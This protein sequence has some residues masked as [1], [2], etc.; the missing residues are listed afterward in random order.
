MR[1]RGFTLVELMVALALGMAVTIAVTLM[2]ARQEGARRTLTSTNDVAMTGAFLSFTLDRQLRSAGSGYSQQWQD[3]FGC[4]MN[5]ARDGD[6]LLPRPGAFPAPFAGVPQDVRLVPVLVHARAGTA[7]SDVLQVLTGAS[8]RG[9]LPVRLRQLS[10]TGSGVRIPNT[11]GLRGGDLVMLADPAL[12]CVLQQVEDGFAGSADQSL[13]FGGDYAAAQVNGVS[14]TAFGVDTLSWVVPLGNV[15]GNTPSFE[16][17]GLGPRGTLFTYDL[18]RLDGSD[19][20]LPVADGVVQLRALYG[21]DSDDDGRLD[22]WADP[23]VAPFDAASLTSGTDDAVRNLRRIVALR[24]GM[25]LRSAL[26]ERDVVANAEVTLFA[27]LGEEFA[28]A[29]EIDDEDRRQRHRPVEFTVP[30]R[31]VLMLP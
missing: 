8:G 27:D 12:G 19:A 15:E 25:V 28:F 13:P 24:V 16:L 4:P 26:I 5:V 31:N 29:V 30:L 22:A 23:A 2:M 7:A 18:L 10:A 6:L 20:P 11:V 17:V 21:I 3:T 14:L 9:E 1:S